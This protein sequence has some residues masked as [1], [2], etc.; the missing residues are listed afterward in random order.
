MKLEENCQHRRQISDRW[1]VTRSGHFRGQI[2]EVSRGRA[3]PPNPRA[4][5]RASGSF[6]DL[7]RPLV[8][9]S[10]LEHGAVSPPRATSIH[11]S[12][13]DV[14]DANKSIGPPLNRSSYRSQT[15]NWFILRSPPSFA[16]STLS[17]Y[18][19]LISRKEKLLL[20][21]CMKRNNRTIET[22]ASEIKR[23]I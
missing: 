6:E 16:N 17:N 8:Y 15:S 12:N 14:N 11:A 1:N 22:C 3:R 18:L 7:S 10:S 2:S 9:S 23:K 20:L 13:L 21:L 4:D 5:T 19:R